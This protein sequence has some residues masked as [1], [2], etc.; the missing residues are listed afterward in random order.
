MDE[1]KCEDCGTTENVSITICPFA[2]EIHNK[3][4]SVALCDKCY[5]E[6]VWDI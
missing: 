6:R 4:V 5:Q 2:K 1:L 3:E